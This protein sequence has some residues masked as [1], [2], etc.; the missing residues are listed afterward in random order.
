MVEGNRRATTRDCVQRQEFDELK[1]KVTIMEPV[2][3]EIKE[4][5]DSVEKMTGRIGRWA[6]WIVTALVSSGLVGGNWGKFLH[7]L[8][9]GSG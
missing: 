4:L 1:Q 3:S 2:L 6:P 5:A 9:T 8:V 7:A